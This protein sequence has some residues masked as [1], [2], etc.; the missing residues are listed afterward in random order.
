MFYRVITLDGT[1][2]IITWVFFI[3]FKQIYVVAY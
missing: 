2:A 1:H 3:Q